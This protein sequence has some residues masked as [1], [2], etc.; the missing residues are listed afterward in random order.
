[1][2]TTSQAPAP[3]PARD[4]LLF[5]V[6]AC[7]IT[8][9]LDAPL[10]IAFARHVEPPP[11]ALPLVGLGA[12][13][14]TIAAFI[15]AARR[16]QLRDVFGR[17]KTNPIWIVIAL[18]IPMALHTVANLIEV[19]LGG[20]PAQWIYPPDK[21]EYI[22]AL[23]FFSV[24]EEFGWRGFAH[25]RMTARFGPI[26]G[27]LI[28]GAVWGIW[29]LGMMFTPEKGLP[30][31]FTIGHYVVELGVYSVALAWIFERGNRSMAVAFAFHAGGHLDNLNHAPESELRI[32]V[33]YF[34][35]VVIVSAL[36]A[37]SFMAKRPENTPAL[38]G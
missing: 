10:A 23:V 15:I 21:P 19:A 33:I 1:M 36:A 18:F 29:H 9:A 17:W 32:R 16:K 8:W 38:T 37:R 14:P 31:L 4:A 5:F 22:A 12:L 25:P 3:S 20:H 28:I 6:L 2:T 26:L 7:G 13:G 35:L 27:S 34:V 11:F 30:D 24:G